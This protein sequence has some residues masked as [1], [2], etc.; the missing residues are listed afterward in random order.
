MKVNVQVRKAADR[1]RKKF[2]KEGQELAPFNPKSVRL[3]CSLSEEEVK[4]LCTCLRYVE[5][6]IP[7]SDRKKS[8]FMIYGEKTGDWTPLRM[9]W[10]TPIYV[11]MQEAR[12]SLAIHQ[13][14]RERLRSLGLNEYAC[15]K[16][17]KLAQ[18]ISYLNDSSNYKFSQAQTSR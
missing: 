1:L 3:P 15:E 14:Q 17:G 10:S 2:E 12:V 9:P 5:E 11:A 8:M 7:E 6:N 13:D 4:D 16:I 18:L